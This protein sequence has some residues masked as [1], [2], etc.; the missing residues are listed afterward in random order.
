[1]TTRARGPLNARRFALAVGGAALVLVAALIVCPLL[2]ALGADGKSH[3][4]LLDP[5]D[6]FT[7]GTTAYQILWQARVPRA[8]AGALAGAGLAAAGV[9]FQALLRNPLAEPYT[10]G[11]SSGASFGAVLAI[12]LGL[13]ASMGTSGVALFAF[14]FAL[15]SVAVIWRLARVGDRLPAAT[16]LLAG[17]TLALTSSA[18]TMLIQYTASFTEATRILRWLMGGLEWIPNADLARSAIVVGIGLAAI[19]P[20]ARALDALAAGDDVAASVGV[21]VRR[22]TA[23]VYVAGSLIVGAVISV[24]GPVGFVGLVVPHVLRSFVGAD[25]RVLLPSAIL[26]GGAF[27]VLCDTIGRLALSPAQIPVGVVTALCGGPFFLA[28]LVGE[29]RRARLWG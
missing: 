12:R 27:V 19:L 25:H 3:L 21:D 9:A 24:A 18:A 17:L 14:A 29:K 5:S 1:M 22:V 7:P 4:G 8:L 28:I 16:L 13:A 20:N 6:A 10:I 15:G 26:A 2:G 23:I 11:V